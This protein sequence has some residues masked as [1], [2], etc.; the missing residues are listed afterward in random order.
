M[1]GALSHAIAVLQTP[2][3]RRALASG[4]AH[5]SA[6]SGN[7]KPLNCI[8]PVARLGPPWKESVSG[9]IAAPLG[10]HFGTE[11]RIRRARDLISIAACPYVRLHYVWVLD[12]LPIIC[13]KMLST[14]SIQGPP[15]KSVLLASPPHCR[16]YSGFVQSKAAAKW[17]QAVSGYVFPMAGEAEPAILDRK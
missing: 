16:E 11:L 8:P 12:V 9:S 7:G 15:P 10:R 1:P 5:R 2:H 13:Q 3:R 4:V 17:E 6:G 14:W